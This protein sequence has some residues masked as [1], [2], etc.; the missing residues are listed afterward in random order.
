[1]VVDNQIDSMFAGNART[2][3]YT[4][5]DDDAV[6]SPP[7]NLAGLT[8]DWTLTLQ[9]SSGKPIVGSAFIIK[10]LALGI[11]VT[12]EPGGVLEV[13]LVPAD[14]DTT[15]PAIYYFELEAFDG[16]GGDVVLAT[17]TLEIKPNVDGS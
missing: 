6:G 14:T 17:G 7:K 10:S 12:D 8:F 3:Q 4:I 16:A 5:T 9:D 13:A 11:T 15:N 2:L 1:M